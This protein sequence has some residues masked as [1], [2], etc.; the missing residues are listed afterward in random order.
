[1]HISDSVNQQVLLTQ[2]EWV[3]VLKLSTMWDFFEI[4]KKVLSD[5]NMGM[6]SK[7]VIERKYKV[8]EWLLEGYNSLAK[9]A[10]TISM[11]E[12]ETGGDLNISDA[13]R[14]PGHCDDCSASA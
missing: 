3:S 7:I 6:M 13:R 1:V 4:R 5:S 8:T 10:E 2:E 14:K 11:K 9:Q 12:A